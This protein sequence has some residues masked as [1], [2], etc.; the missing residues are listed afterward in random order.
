MNLEDF[1]PELRR[2]YVNPIL[3]QSIIGR[4]ISRITIVDCYEY[5][6]GE[7][8]L[9]ASRDSKTGQV[10][11]L[12]VTRYICNVEILPMPFFNETYTELWVSPF[13]P[14]TETLG[15]SRVQNKCNF[16]SI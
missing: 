2:V 14:I 9:I 6:S 11:G 13:P 3:L 4:E 1:H 10:I 5:K 8:I 7:R 15:L 12:F 16:E